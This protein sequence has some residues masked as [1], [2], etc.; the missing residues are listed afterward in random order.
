MH[1][2]VFEM[3][4]SRRLTPKDPDP[5]VMELSIYDI[6]PFYI[7]TKPDSLPRGSRQQ[8]VRFSYIKKGDKDTHDKEW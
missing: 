8:T 5:T 6:C 4:T 1:G 2:T 3:Q 7:I